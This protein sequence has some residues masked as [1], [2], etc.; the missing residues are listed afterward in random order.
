MAGGRFPEPSGSA[1][2]RRPAPNPGPGQ[3]R[4]PSFVLP[5]QAAAAGAAGGQ[6]S[7]TGQQDVLRR[8]PEN[9]NLPPGSPLRLFPRYISRLGGTSHREAPARWP[10]RRATGRASQWPRP[11]VSAAG[12]RGRACARARPA[13]RLVTARLSFL[14]RGPT[15]FETPGKRATA[16]LGQTHPSGAP[17]RGLVGSRLRSP[18]V[19]L[20]VRRGQEGR[21]GSA[22]T[23]E[24]PTPFRGCFHAVAGPA[25]VPAP[26]WSFAFIPD[27][28]VCRLWLRNPTPHGR[29]AGRRALSDTPLGAAG[30]SETPKLQRMGRDGMSSLIFTS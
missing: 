12:G 30:G 17:P 22:P 14:P 7:V 28:S 4:P 26:A 11:D 21:Q 24:T 25:C 18:H 19:P 1:G 10:Q 13:A 9:N 29:D 23:L 3:A 20:T 16:A 27:S 15:A 8:A 6:P 5:A 2:S